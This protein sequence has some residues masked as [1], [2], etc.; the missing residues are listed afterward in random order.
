MSV[1]APSTARSEVSKEKTP[2]ADRTASEPE[3]V[4]R[5]QAET[6]DMSQLCFWSESYASEIYRR[7]RDKLKLRMIFT[8]CPRAMG[9]KMV[10]E[11][12]Q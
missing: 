7:T 8:R 6:F 4:M 12:A 10:A 5:D 9:A 3:E 2:Y 11:E 1:F